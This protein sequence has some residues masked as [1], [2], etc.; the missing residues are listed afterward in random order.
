MA[1]EKDKETV[2]EV[3]APEVKAPVKEPVKK[4][5]FLIKRGAPDKN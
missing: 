4:R 5:G 2:K 1:K 3:S